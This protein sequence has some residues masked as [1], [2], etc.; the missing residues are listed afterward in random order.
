[1][2]TTGAK[3]SIVNQSQVSCALG[4][5]ALEG[6]RVPRMSSGRT[7]PAFA[8]YD[9]NPRA[10]GFVMDRFLTGIRP[11]EY[12][13]HCM[14]GREGLVDT[15]VKTSRSGYLQRCLVKHLEELKVCYDHTVRNGEGGVV[16]FLY[17]ED[18]LDPTKASYLDCSEA[19]FVFMARNHKSLCLATTPFDDAGIERAAEEA[20]LSAISEA[21]SGSKTISAGDFVHARR[22]KAGSLWN[23]GNICE[24][25]HGATVLS[26]NE[27]KDMFDLKFE[28]DGYI[29]RNIPRTVDLGSG[30]SLSSSCT[31]VRIASRLPLISSARASHRLGSNGD[32][33]SERLALSAV[34][35]LHGSKKLQNALESC[36]VSSKEFSSLVAS[37][38]GSSLC[39]PGEAV[40]SIAAQSIGEPSTQ[41]T[42]NTFHLGTI[43]TC[44]TS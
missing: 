36:R 2:V 33:V 25:W 10:D 24:G 8:P 20:R 14:A 4:Q 27:E 3:G 29:A 41:M 5:Q 18:G 35:T 32:C 13:F 21:V 31:V 11:Q 22:L 28:E 23:R 17:G 34:K 16:Q 6:R 37:K 9:I 40:G 43:G 15:A 38:Y 30:K 42:L 44:F 26:S 19:S 1:M 7:L 39:A 12:Y